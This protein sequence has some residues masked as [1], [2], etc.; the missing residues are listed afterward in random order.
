[1]GEFSDRQIQMPDL[2]DKSSFE[3]E[4][5]QK[6]EL[7]NSIQPQK[8]DHMLKQEI[9]HCQQLLLEHE[10]TIASQCTEL[11]KLKQEHET[12][13]RH[14]A[15]LELAFS[16]VLQ[17]YDRSKIIV[18]GF[19]TNEEA[20]TQNLQIAEEKLKQNEAKYESLKTYAKA[21]IEK[22]NVEIM[23]VREK[24]EFESSKLRALIKRLE[25]KCS[26]LE[27]SLNQKTE[28]CQQLSELCD[29]I[30]GKQV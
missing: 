16:D 14:F 27:T 15:T 4:I 17:K 11:E 24:Y 18:D 10:K 26:S 21:Q 22:C 2:Q 28:E 25:I 29:D 19:K 13:S 12:T 6:S 9:N 30:T 20:L 1:M 3:I 8:S 5:R 23:N 7:K